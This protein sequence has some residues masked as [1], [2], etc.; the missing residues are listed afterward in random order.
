[1]FP[2]KVYWMILLFIVIIV[3]GSGCNKKHIGIESI[4]STRKIREK[5]NVLMPELKEK[6]YYMKFPINNHIRVN[7][8]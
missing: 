2:K 4:I 8:E 6:G 3:I 7:N 5:T 1:M